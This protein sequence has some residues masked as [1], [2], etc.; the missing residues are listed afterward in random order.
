MPFFR[1]FIRPTSLLLYIRVYARKT[2][3]PCRPFSQKPVRHTDQGRLRPR[4]VYLFF[5]SLRAKRGNP[6]PVIPTKGV[7]ARVECISRKYTGRYA[8][9]RNCVAS[10]GMTASYKTKSPKLIRLGPLVFILLRLECMDFIVLAYS[11]LSS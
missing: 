10:L 2:K 9:L 5:L 3:L 11:A 6:S 8:R 1:H 4:G 7:Y